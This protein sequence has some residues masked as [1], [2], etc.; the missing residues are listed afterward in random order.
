MYGGLSMEDLRKFR[1]IH[2]KTPSHPESFITNVEVTT[3]PLG[4]GI[5][6]AVGMSIA[7]KHLSAVNKKNTVD[8]LIAFV[9]MGV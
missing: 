1:Q 5:A 2:S 9:E 7:H 3:G 4:Q 6:N 8:I